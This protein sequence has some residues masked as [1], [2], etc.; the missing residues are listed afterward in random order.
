MTVGMLILFSSGRRSVSLSVHYRN[1][2]YIIIQ[3]AVAGNLF[4]MDLYTIKVA[5]I[6]NKR[7]TACSLLAEFVPL[8]YIDKKECVLL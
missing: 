7:A 2:I 4:V 1:F 6:I 5:V 8:I 3:N